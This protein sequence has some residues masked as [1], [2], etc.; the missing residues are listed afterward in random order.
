[1]MICPESFLSEHASDSFDQLL[2]LRSE[3]MND[4][5]AFEQK[6]TPESE[7]MVRPSPEV[8]YQMNLKYLAVL[9]DYIAE[10]YNREFI[11]CNDEDL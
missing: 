2:M 11:N 9:C 6:M 10:R 5:I 3:L 4:I 7:W 1:M 8:L